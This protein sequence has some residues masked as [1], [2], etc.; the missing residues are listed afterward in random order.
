MLSDILDVLISAVLEG[1]A[2][3]LRVRQ[4]GQ[5]GVRY[6]Q[7]AELVTTADLA[8][9]NAMRS[10]FAERL[11]P[12]DHAI[13]FQLEESGSS[14]P[15]GSKWVGADP[16]DGSNHFACGGPF[17]SVQAHYVEDCVPLCG[18][19]FQ[20][21]AFLPLAESERC[22]GRLV[23]AMRGRGAYVERTEFN[24]GGFTRFAKKEVMKLPLPPIHSS[25]AC[26]PFSTKMNPDERSRVLKVYESGAISVTTGVGG[27]GGN[28]MMTVFGGQ[29]VYANLG[30]GEDLD[31]IPPQ[32]IAEEAGLTV[33]DISRRSPRWDV[34][35]QPVI[36]AQS[37]E[38][39][40]RFLQA[41]GY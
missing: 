10:V 22:L 29:Q 36:V 34:R 41:A 38:L 32:V 23:Y 20:P 5:I 40:E 31:L 27:A 33:W 25:A 14:A 17:Y 26:V 18:V 3:I 24:V 7:R 35:K 30:A 37:P 15:V 2:Q 9:D 19:V 16:L 6:K 12:I 1:G 8:S 21:E 28:V 13:T 39:A 11:P 4:A